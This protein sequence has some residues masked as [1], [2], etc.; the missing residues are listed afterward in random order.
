MSTLKS[1][2]DHLTLNAD[3]SSKNILFQADGV[4]KASISSAGLFT[5]TTIDATALTGNLPAISGASLTGL[6]DNTPSFCAYL[7]AD[8]SVS[9]GT[10]VK[11]QFN[12]EV[13]DTN[14]A[15]D[16]SSNYRF[17]V[18]S[19]EAGKYVIM[20]DV[21]GANNDTGA[22]SMNMYLYKNGSV[23]RQANNHLTSNSIKRMHLPLNFIDDA[24]V[25]DYYEC[26]VNLNGSSTIV[27]GGT[28]V[29]GST[30]M[31]YKLII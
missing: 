22:T 29:F 5:S 30:F 9:A 25:S 4:Q 21:H 19:G 24:S 11:I 1:S 31:M 27:E 17:T 10:E 15:Y 16:N 3:G 2:D 20:V 18:P 14:S 28:G 12:T 13:F 6:A 23:F 26:Y 7:S 8:Q